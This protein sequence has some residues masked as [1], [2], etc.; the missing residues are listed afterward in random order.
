MTHIKDKMGDY[1]LKNVQWQIYEDSL[2]EL[3]VPEEEFRRAF[4]DGKLVCPNCGEPYEPEH[5]SREE[6]FERGGQVSR[7]QWMSHICS[8]RCWKA[9]LRGRS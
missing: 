2:R 6:A 7:E 1:P 8:A 4:E 5:P 9:Y 3:G